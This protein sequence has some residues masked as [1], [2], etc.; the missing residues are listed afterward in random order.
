MSWVFRFIANCRNKEKLSRSLDTA[1]TEKAKLFW[2]KHEQQ[3]TEKTDNFKEDEGCL[4]LQ[5]NNA[6]IY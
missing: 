6:G 2:I 1:K 5:E 4:N 3:K